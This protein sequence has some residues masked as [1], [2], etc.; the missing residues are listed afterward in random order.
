MGLAN[1]ENLSATGTAVLSASVIVVM[2]GP[3]PQVTVTVNVQVASGA[4]PFDAMAVTVVVPLENVYGDV[5]V[6]LPIL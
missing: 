4:T 1:T 2:V 3:L 5:M 6:A